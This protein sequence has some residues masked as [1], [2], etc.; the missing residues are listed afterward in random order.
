M[1]THIISKHFA[2]TIK[3]RP[4]DFMSKFLSGQD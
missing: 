1:E 2:V 3:E 4:K